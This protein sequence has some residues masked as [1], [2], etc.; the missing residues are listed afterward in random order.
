MTKLP[1]TTLVG[2]TALLL[3]FLLSATNIEAFSSSSGWL[4]RSL[5]NRSP[6]S[7]S[8][9]K[10][11]HQHRFVSLSRGGGS[12]QRTTTTTMQTIILEDERPRTEEEE[13]RAKQ[14]KRSYQMDMIWTFLN[15]AFLGV[16][17]C[18]IIGEGKFFDSQFMTDGFSNM[19]PL[20]K[21]PT[22][23]A[24]FVFDGS[25][26]AVVFLLA[27]KFWF[28][29]LYL[30]MHGIAHKC[31][32]IGWI[33][34]SLKLTTAPETAI[35]FLILSMGGKGIYDIMTIDAD[36]NKT[37]NKIASV[38]FVKDKKT[39]KKIVAG[40]VSFSVVTFFTW[41]FR[42][43]L[44]KGAYVLT[45][46]NIV[47]NLCIMVPSVILVPATEVHTRLDRFLGPY[48]N[49]YVFLM[50]LMNVVIWIEPLFGSRPL[51]C[52]FNLRPVFCSSF[53]KIGG[54]IWFDISLFMVMFLNIFYRKLIE[55]KNRG[56]ESLR[57]GTD[58]RTGIETR[59]RL[60]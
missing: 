3:L 36:E 11:K 51:F 29:A 21:S 49:Q 53:A 60:W 15:F 6:L 55:E 58:K 47:I 24:C 22:Q 28:Q 40:T 56:K 16:W 14:A 1:L 10:Q 52:S 57:I 31:I 50:T 35:L 19:P 17:L 4:R 37:L 41:L 23:N 34:P 59:F 30:L 7:T 8:W 25:M 5:H 46:V 48:F 39:A 54:H 26:A 32:D 43:Y 33:D 12:K 13:K 18:Q 2:G 45:Y 38:P 44:K 9:T 42:R 20:D 27:P